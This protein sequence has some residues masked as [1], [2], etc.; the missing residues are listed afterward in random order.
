MGPTV[1]LLFPDEV[2][3]SPLVKV[4][5]GGPSAEFV[6][7]WGTCDAEGIIVVEID[8]LLTGG[9]AKHQAKIKRRMAWGLD[10]AS[11]RETAIVSFFDFNTVETV[12]LGCG[13]FTSLAGVM[14]Q[15]GAFELGYRPE[16]AAQRDVITYVLTTV[17]IASLVYV[18]AVFLN[19]A[20]TA[21]HRDTKVAEKKGGKAKKGGKEGAKSPFAGDAEDL[22]A[23]SDS[24]SAPS[25]APAA[26]DSVTS[27]S[28]QVNPM[29]M[30]GGG[31]NQVGTSAASI[32]EGGG[33]PDAAS[34]EVVKL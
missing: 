22:M 32:I 31:A 10:R 28:A 27:D 12:L 18:F 19:E 25:K 17:L 14:F 13:V 16:V 3:D 30:C 20:Y 24:G 26:E 7:D 2:R 23:S 5:F 6:D 33:V 8:D 1:F 11:M 4:S 29:F 15:S 21:C 34:W 9:S